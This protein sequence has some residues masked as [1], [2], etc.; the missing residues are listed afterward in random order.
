MKPLD[1]NKLDLIRKIALIRA[2]AKSPVIEVKAQAEENDLQL[3]SDDSDF[4]PG[5]L[6]PLD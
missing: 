4:I 5:K 1:N 2:L 6:T 3:S